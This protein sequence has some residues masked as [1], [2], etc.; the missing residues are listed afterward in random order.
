MLHLISTSPFQN[1]AIPECRKIAQDGDVLLLLGDAVYAA[2]T[3]EK[4]FSGLQIFALAEHVAA[5]GIAAPAWITCIDY[6]QMVELTCQHHPVQT[7][8]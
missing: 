7:W 3:E 1:S 4:L 6:N 2:L 5:R 8:C